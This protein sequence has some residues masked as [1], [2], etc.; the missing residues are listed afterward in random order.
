M[1]PAHQAREVRRSR[2]GVN[3]CLEGFNEARASSAGSNWP[4]AENQVRRRRF[5]EARASSAGSKGWNTNSRRQ[6]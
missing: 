2:F 3:R 6:T 1:R 4:I 5:N